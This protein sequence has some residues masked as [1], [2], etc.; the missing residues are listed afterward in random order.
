VALANSGCLVAAAGAAGGA[1][2]GYAYY[3]GKVQQDYNATF[4]DTWAATHAALA[5]L[6]MP[7]VSE[8]RE[9]ATS[10]FIESR[11]ADNDR[12][13]IS[14]ESF[15]SPFPAEGVLTRLGVRVGTFGDYPLSD[16]IASQVGAHLVPRAA[17][18][19]PGAP[20]ASPINVLPTQPFSP[21][22]YPP[23][24]AEPPLLKPNPGS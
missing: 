6:G 4:E 12:V 7:V 2:V 8:S 22:A 17:P 15:P 16:R 14:L 21:A 9:S 10:G 1:A 11:D 19:P 20:S 3:K 18:A 13:G 24:T 5:E 23:Q